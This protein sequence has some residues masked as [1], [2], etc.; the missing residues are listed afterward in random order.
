MKYLI[1]Y[2]LIIHTT[3]IFSQEELKGKYYV[4]NPMG[5]FSETIEFKENNEFYY[6]TSG[7]LGTESY[8]NGIYFFDKNLLILNYKNTEPLELSYY[9]SKFWVNKNKKIQL[10]VYVQDLNGEKVP[11]AN[12]YIDKS[13]IGV[14]ADENGFGELTIDKSDNIS[15]LIISNIGF[16]RQKLEFRNDF[17]YE[18]NVFLKK[19]DFPT[20]IFNEIDSLKIFEKKKKEF[21]TLDRNNVKK[22]WK[23]SE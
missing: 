11:Y 3:F 18:F 22:L 21:K 8:G 4:P 23:K 20:P 6:K 15:E 12:I 19:G 1:F 7:C 5:N 14:V 10:K 13:K 17:N 16:I 2:F 9:K